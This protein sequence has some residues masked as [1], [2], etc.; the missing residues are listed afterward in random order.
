MR[1][2]VVEDSDLVFATLSEVL[3]E[4]AGVEVVGRAVSEAG[5]IALV[6]RERPEVVLLDLALSPGSGLAV[7]RRIRQEGCAA[8]VFVVSNES[9]AMLRAHCIA[10]GADG[11]F[12]KCADL[13]ALLAALQQRERIDWEGGL[14]VDA[15]PALDLSTRH[16]LQSIVSRAAHATGC[17]MAAVTL[18]GRARQWLVAR[19][20]LELDSTSR[21]V[22]FCSHTVEQ[23]RLLEVHDASDDPRFARNP[24]VEVAGIRFY[25]GSA[26]R[27]PDGTAIGALCVLDTRPGALGPREQALLEA[28]AAEASRALGPA[29]DGAPAAADDAHDGLTGLLRRETLSEAIAPVP[30]PTGHWRA[31]LMVGIDDFSCINHTFGRRTGDRV[32]HELAWRIA[33]LVPGAAV[34]RTGGDEFGV[35]LHAAVDEPMLLAIAE[36]VAA[37]VGEP[38]DLKGRD[39]RLRC[40]IGFTLASGGSDPADRLLG[41]AELAMRQAK[42]LGGDRCQA[43]AGWMDTLAVDRV[44]LEAE[45]RQGL[46]SHQFLPVYQP[47]VDLRSG[48]IVGVE[49]LARWAHPGR[50]L[51]SPDRFIPLAEECGLIADLGAR[52][53]DAALAQQAA[54]RA[55]GIAPARMAV[56]VSAR[57]L[58]PG[59]VDEIRH[60]LARHQIDPHQLEIEVTESALP[61]D[62]A[63]ARAVLAGLR[64]MGVGVA[65]DDFGVGYSSL[66]ALRA[67]PVGTLKV[68]RCFVSGIAHAAADMAMVGAMVA[69]GHGLDMRVIAEGVEDA[70]QEASLLAVGCELAQGYLYGRPMHS[71]Q[72][73]ELLKE[74]V[75]DSPAVREKRAVMSASAP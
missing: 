42:D 24:L 51:L 12:D 9:G 53:L 71:E 3:A 61:R 29:L 63:V 68:D 72:M 40:S 30:L 31:C 26:L 45:L 47:Q 39:V 2:V 54:W 18:L 52:I 25:A 58:V 22:A 62:D 5:A 74:R 55:I 19:R 44:L 69:M 16:V 8:R 20:G 17:P 1:I 27:A 34:A 23:E 65:L 41:R 6:L 50:G 7:L 11:F 73:A 48:R 70:A 32:L 38:F 28:L 60:A 15:P 75:L 67:A 4:C 46:R 59:Y 33:S 57:Q 35:L 36:C 13:G 56:N 66:S 43:H 21:H 49:A 64:A 10:A 37:A 14:E